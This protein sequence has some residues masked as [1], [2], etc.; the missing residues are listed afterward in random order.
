[1]NGWELRASELERE[2]G[3]QAMA[4]CQDWPEGPGV[5]LGSGGSSGGRKW[6]LQSWA[7][8]EQSASSCRQWLQGLGI[9]PN[10]VRLVNTLPSHHMGGLMPE[11]RAR[12]WEVPLVSLTPEL[13][14]SPATLLEGHGNLTSDGRDALI[15]LVPTQLQRLLADPSGCHWLQQFRLLWIGGGPLSQE[16]AH[17]ARQL[18]LP[19][20]PC[21]GSTE[22]AAMICALDPAHFLAGQSS[23]GSPFHDVQLQLDQASGAVAVKTKR[24]SPGWLKGT[25]LQPFSDEN[26]WWQSGDAGRLGPAG[27]ELLGRLDSALNSGGATVFPEQIE[28]FL[29]G[30]PGLEALLVVGLPDQEW[31]QRLIGLVKPS[32]GADGNDLVQRLQEQ[33]ASLPPAQRP[34]QWRLCPEL[35]PNPQGKWERRRWCDWAQ[36]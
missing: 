25:Q 28:A 32:P 9:D 4:T 31:G 14:K 1:M 35:K 3:Q 12:Q 20:S 5:V 30:L 11:I 21:Y 34:K 7:N 17:Q 29:D 13:L 10:G 36:A 8:L 23:S 15:S 26:G 16:L 33:S 27:L 24:L 6:C 19:L 18:Q 2:A 22:T